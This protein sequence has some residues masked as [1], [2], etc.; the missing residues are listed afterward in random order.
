MLTPLLPVTALA[1]LPNHLFSVAVPLLNKFF[2]YSARLGKTSYLSIQDKRRKISHLV[3]W[4]NSVFSSYSS[5]WECLPVS[6]LEPDRILWLDGCW[7]F[8]LQ[9]FVSAFPLV[10]VR[11]LKLCLHHLHRFHSLCP[12][13]IIFTF[14]LTVMLN[15]GKKQR[16][17]ECPVFN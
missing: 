5:T 13:K 1:C 3:H 16:K 4:T 2:A 7:L 15:L 6:V 12:F 9:T 8:L 10:L 17:F 11:M 14:P